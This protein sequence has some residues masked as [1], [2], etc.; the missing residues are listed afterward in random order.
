[1]AFHRTCKSNK[2]E[3]DKLRKSKTCPNLQ[4][5]CYYLDDVGYKAKVGKYSNAKFLSDYGYASQTNSS[6]STNEVYISSLDTFLSGI[7]DDFDFDEFAMSR[8]HDV[9]DVMEKLKID[10]K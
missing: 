3:F 4:T 10:Q 8:T 1:M 7:F 5:L 2:K 9:S 6:I